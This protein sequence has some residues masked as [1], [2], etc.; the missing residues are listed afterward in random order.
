MQQSAARVRRGIARAGVSAAVAL[1]VA[2]APAT[3]GAATQSR[4]D[5]SDVTPGAVG[6][7]DLRTIA[8]DVGASTTTLTVTVDESTYG[9]GNRAELGVH[10]FIDVTGDGIADHEITAARAADGLKMDVV[11][12]ELSGIAS[13]ADCQDLDGKATGAAATVATTIANGLETFSFSFPTATVPGDL[14]SFRWAAFGQSPPD[15]GQGGPWDYLVDAANPDAAAR[16]SGR[17]PLRRG[18]GRS[19]AAAQRRHRVPRP[20]AGAV[21]E[22]RT[23]PVA[24]HPAAR[25]GS[26]SRVDRPSPGS[27]SRSTRP[28][29]RRRPAR[30]SSPSNGTS[31][32]TARSTRTPA[33][34]RS[35]T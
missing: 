9:G 18:E 34:T 31:T 12:R 30:R 17:P 27:R 6:E 24:G 32:A 22:P 25:G 14:A 28:G 35:P 33:R 29:R 21:A 13:T 4:D 23:E 5:A 16:E 7:T 3:A 26:R 8:W 1:A 10:V 20:S 11:L 19:R 15:A 2:V